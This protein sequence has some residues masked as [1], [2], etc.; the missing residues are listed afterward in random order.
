M[1]TQLVHY[2]RKKK[3]R[4]VPFLA[5]LDSNGIVLDMY[6]TRVGCCIWERKQQI[7]TWRKEKRNV[8][9]ESVGNTNVSF[10]KG[11]RTNE[12]TNGRLEH[13]TGYILYVRS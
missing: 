2:Q 1:Q 7:R 3:T 12:R 8:G 6:Y 11:D 4:L 13:T 9:F 10:N 5:L